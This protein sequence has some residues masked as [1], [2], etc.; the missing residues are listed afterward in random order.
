M[1]RVIA[2]EK[3]LPTSVKRAHLEG[4]PDG[5]EEKGVS[6]DKLNEFMSEIDEK[7][8][9][10]PDSYPSYEI[11]PERLKEWIAMHRVPRSIRAAEIFASHIR[12]IGFVEWYDS[13]VRATDAF[14]KTVRS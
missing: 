7:Q 5:K 9:S 6:T 10:P 11:N 1:K 14:L 12:R 13:L 2:E 3:A 8:L 4:T